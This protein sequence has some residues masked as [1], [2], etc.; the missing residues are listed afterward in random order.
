MH[1]KV[2]VH[3]SEAMLNLDNEQETPSLSW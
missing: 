2:L 3:V 1:L